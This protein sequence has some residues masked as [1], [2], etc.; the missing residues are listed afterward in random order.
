M[1]RSSTRHSREIHGLDSQGY[2]A[3]DFGEKN[4]FTAKGVTPKQA[5][6]QPS[7]TLPDVDIDGNPD[8]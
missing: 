5:G 8:P 6:G 1:P 4:D 2:T 7:Y 3:P